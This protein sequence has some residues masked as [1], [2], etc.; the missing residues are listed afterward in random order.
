MTGFIGVVCKTLTIMATCSL[1]IY[2]SSYSETRTIYGLH[3]DDTVR[4]I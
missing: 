3:A 1:I 2:K 4:Y